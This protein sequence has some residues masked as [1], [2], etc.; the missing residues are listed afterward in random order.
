MR[1]NDLQNPVVGRPMNIC[2]YKGGGGGG[3]HPF[4][5][6][7]YLC[8]SRAAFHKSDDNESWYPADGSRRNGEGNNL[9]R[10][11]HG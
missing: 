10:F 1:D 11:R 6:H 4:V 7:A 5:F 2:S 9:F 8:I 3:G